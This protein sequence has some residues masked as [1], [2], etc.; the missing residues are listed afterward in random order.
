MNT[1][2]VVDDNIAICRA[3]TLIL[4][5]HDYQVLSCQSAQDALAI[6]QTQEIALVIQDMN[7]TKD[8]TSGE[9]GKSLFFQIRKHQSDVPI[10]LMTAWT[11]LETAVELVK[12][13]AADYM[14]KPWDDAKLLTSVGNLVSLYQLSQ[15]NRQLTRVND[16]RMSHISQA[17]L[18]GLVFA[19]GAMQ[20]CID[21]TLQLANSDVSVL[22]TG[23][24]GAGK[25]KIADILHA[26][27]PLNKKAF[28]KVNA[29]ALPTDL[30]EA[31]LFGAEAGA[32]TGNTKTRIGRFEA[33]DGGTLFLDEIGNLPLSGQVKLLRVLQTGEFERLGSAKTHKTNV[34]V[35]S[36]TNANLMDA[37]SKGH[38]REDLYYRLNVVELELPPLNQ[39]GDDILPLA[40]HFMG[41]SYQFNKSA[42]Q[43]LLTHPWPGNVR[44]LEN[45]CK[46]AKL[47]AKS[48]VVD[49][50]DF[51][52]S[53]SH[54]PL[55][56]QT[57]RGVN[58]PKFTPACDNTNHDMSTH[59]NT[60]PITRDMIEAALNKHH[61]VISRAAKYLGI[62]RQ[63]LYRRMEKL[64]IEQP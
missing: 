1:I 10:I 21:L 60:G 15:T 34:R 32:F 9:E 8:T 13:G 50:Q 29:G 43:A 25:D 14:S 57:L 39:R 56:N 28:I 59:N 26:N 61:G 7:F 19:S 12:A 3:L 63:A 49:A 20:R 31:E 27:S 48:H 18:C 42:Q 41:N 6:F 16:D 46:R 55:D 51:G 47:L 58:A 22:I 11:Q 37:I 38:F 53:Q 23:P 52:I 40:K 2:L 64:N 33:A 30:L 36:A 5:L 62:S 24:N 45:A 17:N 44:E 54:P 4:E 35:L